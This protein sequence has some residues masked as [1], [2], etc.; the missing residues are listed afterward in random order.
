MNKKWILVLAAA[1]AGG[2]M[3]AQFRKRAE[4][5]EKPLPSQALYHR[6]APLYDRLFGA[7]Y[8]GARRRAVRLLDLQ[9]GERLLISGVGTGLD[10]PLLPCGVE[11]VGVDIS[12]EMLAQAA[13]K[14]SAASV[15]LCRMDAQRLDFADGEFDAALLNLVVSVAPDGRA[16]FCEAWR[17]LRPGGRLVLFDKFA[18]EGQAIGPLRSAAGALFRQVGTD[19]NRRLSDVLGDLDG[20]EIVWQEP[21]LFWGLYRL[22]RIEKKN[23]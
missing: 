10:L 18:H 2:W 16:V 6:F 19:I 17:T 5:A 3:V 1:V 23:H 20:G 13:K 14:F 9:A 21:S 22:L 7:P 15:R 12:G 4:T 8:A 11:A